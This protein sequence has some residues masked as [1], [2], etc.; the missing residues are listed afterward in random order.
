VRGTPLDLFA[1]TEVR[2]VE[3]ALPDEYR[4]LV[5]RSLAELTPA[6]VAAVAEIAGLPDLVR[7]Y[8]E[9]KL[10][11]V[12]EFRRRGDR[13]VASLIEDGEQDVVDVQSP[14]RI[15]RRGPAPDRARSARAAAR[16][17]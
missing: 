10:A 13:L 2:R 12:V 6:N 4:A 5:D 1:R 17:G 9:I 11:N 8:E 16:R 7:G 14:L 15:T 3:R